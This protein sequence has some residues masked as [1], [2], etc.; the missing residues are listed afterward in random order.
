MDESVKTRPP[1]E[2]YPRKWPK[3]HIGGAS[4]MEHCN[5][6]RTDKVC[7]STASFTRIIMSTVEMSGPHDTLYPLCAHKK[8]IG[9]L[10]SDKN[11]VRIYP[12]PLKNT[13]QTA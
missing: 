4:S 5:K 7:E 8:H 13:A 12:P 2:S 11:K 1:S 9:E 10:T 3:E 6:T